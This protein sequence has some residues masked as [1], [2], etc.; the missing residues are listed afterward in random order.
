[1]ANILLAIFIVALAAAW[2]RSGYWTP[3]APAAT[4]SRRRLL[5]VAGGL[6]AVLTA[7]FSLGDV[8][9]GRTQISRDPVRYASRLQGIDAHGHGLL[10]SARYWEQI[11]LQTVVGLIVA[12]SLVFLSRP[13]LARERARA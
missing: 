12:G 9:G 2:R 1:M 3:W 6:V 11:M 10:D 5:L 4:P 7:G 8:L 13:T